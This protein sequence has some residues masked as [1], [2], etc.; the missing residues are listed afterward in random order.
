MM[1]Q[2]SFAC[3]KQLMWTMVFSQKNSF[4]QLDRILILMIKKTKALEIGEIHFKTHLSACASL[5]KN[6]S[7]ILLKT[8]KNK[9]I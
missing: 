3:S 9:M 5:T 2:E 1:F 7:F 4:S 6:I 8:L